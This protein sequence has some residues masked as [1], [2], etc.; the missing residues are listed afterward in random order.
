MGRFIPPPETSQF[1]PV[2]RVG[3]GERRRAIYNWDY[4]SRT[5][6][7]SR[8]SGQI[9]RGQNWTVEIIATSADALAVNP[10]LWPAICHSELGAI[11]HGGFLPICDATQ[12]NGGVGGNGMVARKVSPLSSL[13]FQHTKLP[14]TGK[15]SQAYMSSTNNYTPPQPLLSRRRRHHHRHYHRRSST[16]LRGEKFLSRLETSGA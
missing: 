6:R 4:Q 7:L 9:A 3:R 16:S 14:A 15:I 5:V 2:V 10:R 12:G 11:R 1:I 8:Q 13:C